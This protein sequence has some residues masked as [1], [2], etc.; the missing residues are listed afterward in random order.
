MASRQAAKSGR[1]TAQTT[2]TQASAATA[3][4]ATATFAGI[5]IKPARKKPGHEK[6]EVGPLCLRVPSFASKCG[7]AAVQSGHHETPVSLFLAPVAN[8]TT[9]VPT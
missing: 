6:Q 5:K 7:S 4:T 1:S 2:N 8:T 9:D 3:V